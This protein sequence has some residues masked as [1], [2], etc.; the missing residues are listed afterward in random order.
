MAFPLSLALILSLPGQSPPDRDKSNGPA[1]RLDVMKDSLA[2]ARVRADDDHGDSYRLRTDPILRFTNTVG[3]SRDGA[4]FL[5]LGVGDR[6][7][8]AVQVF[9]KRDGT[10]HQEW[11]S[12]STSPL[13][14]HLAAAAEW[15]PSRGGVDFKP[16]PGAGRPAETAD[17]RLRQ[18]QTLTR[19]FSASD[20]FHGRSWQPLRLLP[21]PLARYGKPGSE[22]TDGALFTYVLTTD[23]EVFLMIEARA[24]K[25]GPEW[26]YAFAPSSIF[27]LQGLWKGQVVWSLA[28]RPYRDPNG[29]FYLREFQPGE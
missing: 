22:V 7:A 29:S 13:T 28:F 25:G 18:M 4:T 8:A 2:R 9:L 5:W 19:D 12:L 10:W 27:P 16:V 6:P 24:G 26:Q 3:D 11:S 23:P 17:Q 20:Y 14:A 21:K 1:A 15:K